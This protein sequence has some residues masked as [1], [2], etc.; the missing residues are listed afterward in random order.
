ME[1]SQKSAKGVHLQDLA[2]Y[3]DKRRAAAIWIAAVGIGYLRA[4]FKGQLA[5][6]GRGPADA[7]DLVQETLIAVH[8]KRHTYDRSQLL[9]SWV[10]AIA[11]HRQSHRSL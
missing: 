5:R 2:D 9:S 3:P 1:N 4:Y 10:Y 7:E 8:T 11:R 6:V